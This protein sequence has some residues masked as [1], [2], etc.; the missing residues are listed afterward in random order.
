MSFA[1]ELN[2][3]QSNRTLEQARRRQTEIMLE[4]RAGT[5]DHPIVGELQPT[6]T[7]ELSLKIRSNPGIVIPKA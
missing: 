6:E 3:R 7:D 4:T 2:Q 5:E 1:I